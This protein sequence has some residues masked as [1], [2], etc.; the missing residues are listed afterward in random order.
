M[1]AASHFQEDIFRFIREERGNLVVQACAGSGKTSTIVMA[2][3]HV[4]SR[5]SVL[6]LAFATQAAE[7]LADKVPKGIGVRTL[8]SYGFAVVRRH[9]RAVVYNKFRLPNLVRVVLGNDPDES[10][11]RD[12][13]AEIVRYAKGALASTPEELDDLIDEYD[14]EQGE[15]S[16]ERGELVA[17]AARVLKLCRDPHCAGAP[18]DPK[19]GKWSP[20]WRLVSPPAPE[21][22]YDDM[23]WLPVVLNIPG[24]QYDFVFVDETQD[25]NPCQIE[26]AMRIPR[27]PEGR[28]CALGDRR[29]SIYR[30]RGA[31]ASA[32]GNV[33]RRLGATTLPLSVSYRC[34]RRIVDV[35]QRLAPE[36]EAA[37]GAPEGL[38]EDI[39]VAD[40][41]ERLE[42]GDMVLGRSNAPLVALCVSLIAEDRAAVI[43][44][45][46]VGE[47]LVRFVKRS[48]QRTVAGLLQYIESWLGAEIA[49]LGCRE[50]PRSTRG[51]EDK[52][53]VLRR[54]AD[55]ADSVARVIERLE[56][57]FSNDVF[58]EIIT[59]STTHKAKGQ[60]RERVFVLVD[61]YASDR[62]TE[63]E[64]LFY[65][66]V[67]RA[68][69][70][71]Y[72]VHGDVSELDDMQFAE[73]GEDEEQSGG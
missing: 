22:D 6:V 54:A 65:V 30:F 57:L 36:I 56:G 11:D 43:Q 66:A 39:T 50:P 20:E 42:P 34:A 62:S 4:P 21:V 45:R 7:D 8:H 18:V 41:M 61:T 19:R 70:E 48:R 29:Q 64:N 17:A 23:C 27:S 53:E 10:D 49:R 3:D 60:E 51:A 25:L 32:M 38:V 68:R 15:L 63:E 40:M 13:V 44:G 1:I 26:L 33:V 46:D 69:S 73:G 14:L 28:V 52:A 2:L 55:G 9:F 35:A 24:A 16:L 72:L 31:D 47:M 37:P 12:A 59:L 5:A 71:L 67:T 58:G